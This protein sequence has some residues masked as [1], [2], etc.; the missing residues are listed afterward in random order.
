MRL[1][2]NIRIGIIMLAFICANAIFLGFYKDVWW[3]SSVYIGMGKYIYSSGHSGLWEDYRMPLFPLV[4]GFGWLLDTDIVLYSRT[5]SLIFACLALFMTYKL[6]K[7]LFSEETGLLASFFLAFSYTFFFFSGNILTE[8]P[9]A[10]FV[11]VSFYLFFRQRYILSGLFAGIS[12]MFRIF[13]SFVFIG[14]LAAFVL[15]EYNKKGFASKIS[16][17]L[18]GL[19]CLIVPYL[20]FN[21][22]MY[23]DVLRPFKIQTFFVHT[24]AWN[25]YR[26]WMFYPIGLAKENFLLA[27][28]LIAPLLIHKNR[29]L[30]G[31]R[32][33]ALSASV[34][35]YILFY[36][37]A[38]HKEM[39]FMIAALPILYILLSI[40][41]FEIYK[42]MEFKKIAALIFIAMALA[43]IFITF[44]KISS[45]I[46]YQQQRNDEAL[47]FFQSKINEKNGTIWITS[48]T[49]ALHSDKKIDGLLYY[50]SPKS[51]MEFAAGN[52][53]DIA[54]ANDCDIMCAPKEDDPYC[55]ISHI[56]L[57]EK[58][59]NHKKIY[60]KRVNS[61]NYEI[62]TS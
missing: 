12:V 32:I 7:E 41:L 44:S 62:F 27:A 59:G 22:F 11:M 2:G 15:R 60:S 53:F 58:L 29:K 24:T 13:H 46:S 57:Y 18:A 17:Y 30:T 36:S 26:G 38:R 14:I 20:S 54:F 55:E 10:F 43:W 6:G 50:Y 40:L 21:F 19:L 1:S 8:I 35:L 34:I 9:S 42:K 4:L 52:D 45:A 3:D 51:L 49:Y 5:V 33:F 61:C 31:H 37:F 47:L 39:R 23:G 48:P 25:L 56:K 16:S 28:L